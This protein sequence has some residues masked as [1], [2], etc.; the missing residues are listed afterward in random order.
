M[1]GSRVHRI[2]GDK[3]AG[4]HYASGGFV[5]PLALKDV[6]LALAEAEAAG[7]PMPSVSVL[8][9]RLISGIARGYAELDW[10]ALGLL[11]AEE[12]GLD[13]EHSVHTG[14]LE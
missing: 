1:F 11:A 9:D 3:I 8:R 7:V 4:R 10:S 2:Y 6:R 5:F 14:V 13:R 12:A